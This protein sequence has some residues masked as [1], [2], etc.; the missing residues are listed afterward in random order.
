MARRSRNPD[1]DSWTA[2]T[3]MVLW[4]S[5]VTDLTLDVDD[6]VDGVGGG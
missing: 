6:A 5:L 3:L 1:L 2:F 4:V